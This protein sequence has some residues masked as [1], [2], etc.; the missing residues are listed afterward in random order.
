[1]PPVVPPA[2]D[3]PRGPADRRLLAILGVV[4]AIMI[5]G[6]LLLFLPH[7]AK[8]PPQQAAKLATAT[9][10]ATPTPT[11]TK[12]APS[13]A[14][15]AQVKT[16]DALMRM[17][18]HGRADAVK[19]DFAAAVANRESLLRRID[20][21]HAGAAAPA[22]RAGLTSFAAAVR[23]ALRQ[24]RTCRADCWAA[25]VAQVGRLKQAA[26]DRLDPLLRRYAG[27][28]YRREQI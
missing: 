4:V 14:L 22:L 26:L 20:R 15:A 19:G 10:T 13:P 27:T 21:L 17:S 2:A 25:D 16:L 24:N 12:A 28:T 7:G 9:A 1:M 8:H 6:L 18:E 23:E 5:G 11:A 3:E